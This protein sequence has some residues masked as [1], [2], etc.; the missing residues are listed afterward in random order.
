MGKSWNEERGV[1]EVGTLV[2]KEKAPGM[3]AHSTHF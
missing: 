2:N 3:K 1:S